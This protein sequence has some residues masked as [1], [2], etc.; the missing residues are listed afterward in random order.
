MKCF[1]L[2]IAVQC[3]AQPLLTLQDAISMAVHDNRQ[4]QISTLDITKATEATAEARTAR[5]PQFNTYILAGSTLNDITFTIPRG[6]LG[7]YPAVGPLPGQDANISTSPTLAGVIF[8]SAAQPISQLYKIGLGIQESQLGEQ[9]AR[10]NLRQ[11]RQ[12]TAQQVRQS[13]YQLVQT[14]SQITSAEAT[15]K[16]LTELSALTDRNLAE[17]TVLKSDSLTVKAKLSQQRYQ[18]L[19]LRDALAT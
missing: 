5:F 4:V 17:E 11:T 19:T 18:L 12:E 3:C 16:Y 1:L 14:Q 7:V 13:Y 2:L 15:L 8:G 10:E 9:L 6:T